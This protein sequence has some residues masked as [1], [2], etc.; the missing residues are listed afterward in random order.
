[1]LYA[2]GK[3][4]GRGYRTA[5]RVFVAAVIGGGLFVFA[6]CSADRVAEDRDAVV[7]YQERQAAE[8][9]RKAAE[10]RARIEAA[11]T[12][13]QRA[14]EAAAREEAV[15]REA[16]RKAEADAK[17][18]AWDAA[19]DKAGVGI[20]RL[21]WWQQCARWGREVRRSRD[22]ASS[23]AFRRALYNQSMI[24]AADE[25]AVIAKE[26]LPIPG[27]T[28]CGAR[29]L[30]GDESTSNV[31]TSVDATRVQLVYRERGVYVYT[32]GSAGDHNGIVTSVSY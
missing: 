20:E 17:T 30:L 15:R 1:M 10:E 4:L 7:R 6:K 13:E 23:E 26:R 2:L 22:S 31:R 24:N 29:A 21:K 16:K 18:A 11:K 27:M 25:A 3:M 19:V 5:P 32:E 8:T 12:P 9:A 14:S 28:G